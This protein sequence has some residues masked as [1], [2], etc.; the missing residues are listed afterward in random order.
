MTSNVQAV[1][2][3][4]SC[5]QL[6]AFKAAAFGVT[7]TIC[8]LPGFSTLSGVSMGQIVS[9]VEATLSPL[10]TNGGLQAF[11]PEGWLE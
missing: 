11:K 2:A 4:G 1:P 6:V 9:A 8:G 7:N 10:S 5:Y 3:A